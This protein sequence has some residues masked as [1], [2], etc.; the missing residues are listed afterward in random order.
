MD[1]TRN[2]SQLLLPIR[3]SAQM[4]QF[5]LGQGFEPVTGTLWIVPNTPEGRMQAREVEASYAA[6]SR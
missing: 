2:T 6:A 1:N 3:P 4:K 5:L